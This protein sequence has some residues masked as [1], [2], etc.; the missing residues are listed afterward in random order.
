MLHSFTFNGRDSREFGLYIAKK[1]SYDKPSRDMS[2]QAVPGRNGDII[3]DNGGYNNL[4]VTLGLRLF[5]KQIAP[6]WGNHDFAEAYKK[7]VDW[8]MVEPN[9]YEYT[10]TYDPDYY[11]LGCIKSGIK[12]TQKRYDVV[13]LSLSLSFK[14]YK[15]RM[16]SE[17][18][19]LTNQG[20]IVNY[21]TSDSLPLMRIYTALTYDANTETHHYFAVG[22][23]TYR[24]DNI[25]EY[26]D[27]D[28]ELMEVFKGT[29]PMNSNYKN[30]TFPVLAVGSNLI[31]PIQ[32]VSKIVIYPRWRS[33]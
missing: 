14:P 13:D 28:S 24:V 32:N 12:V 3:I 33:L 7:V 11:R 17:P 6:E 4:D 29:T 9:Y 30:D 25:N 15:Y 20:T 21:E 26:V 18:V 23:K 27:I 22:S 19:E 1:Q 10:D 5:V 31:A 16:H 8:L 2:F